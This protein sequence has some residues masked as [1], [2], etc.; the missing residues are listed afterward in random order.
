MLLSKISNLLAQPLNL[1]L[2]LFV[3]GFW[4]ERK[5]PRTARRLLFIGV[6]LLVITGMRPLSDAAL[7]ALEE[8]SPE[9]SAND[10]FSGY[11]GMVVLG[12]SLDA[13]RIAEHYQQ[14]LLKGSAERLTMAVTLWR[15]NPALRIVFTG[16]EG[17]LFGSG[18]SEA[19]QAQKFF[20]SQGL[21]REAL[22]LETRSSNTYEN[23]AFTHKLSGVEPQ[24][25]WLLV[26]SAWHMPRSL[27]VFRKAG[28]N[29]TPFPVDFR[30]ADRAPWF[31]FSLREGADQW[32]TALHEW[33]GI[34][35]YRLLGRI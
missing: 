25:R 19:E 8:Q 1:A 31:D 17:D 20:E 28:W 32:E 4:W 21:P 35:A 34:A 2:L 12:G 24:Q 3:L 13:G 18:P 30:T 27:A 7:S 22:T 15:R 5:K 16:G 23:A 14:P 10:S 9:V 29:V 6:L 11:A 33:L 26:T